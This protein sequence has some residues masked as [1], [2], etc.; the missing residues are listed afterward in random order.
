MPISERF[1]GLGAI[2]GDWGRS[3]VCI[4]V[5]DGVHRGHRAIIDAT[6]RLADVVGGRVVAATFDP[7]PSAVVRPD[8]Q[9]LMLSTLDQ[10]VALLGEAGADAVLVLTFT[11][12]LATW[13][14]AE[15]VERVLVDGLHAAGVVVGEG[16][17][18][19]HRAAGDVALLEKLGAAHDFVVA[20]L[21]LE[22]GAVVEQ[23][24]AGQVAWSSTYI[25]QCVLEG[26]V[27]EAARALQRPHRIE[28]V[29]VH[30][31]HRGR[32]LGYPTANL[33]PVVHAAVPADGVY[34]GWLVR[35]GVRSAESLPVAISIGTNPTFDGEERRVEAYVLD[36]T[37]LDLY[38]E[39]VAFDF[40]ERLRPTLKFD[41]VDPLLV[42]MKQDVDR[43]RAVL[44][45][46]HH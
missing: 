10:R 46:R 18:F 22:V 1:D 13:T 38:G 24:D 3:V 14:P 40:V 9:P 19:G 16:F 20:P 43:A 45:A 30:G 8:T 26:D 5:F 25:R 33:D 7:H 11:P 36:R 41:G 42:Q 31:D 2:P 35:G 27:A 29:V 23:G 21:S 32:E 17:R 12:E 4:G 15:F 39:N 6:R 37:D 44:T 28:G 34:A